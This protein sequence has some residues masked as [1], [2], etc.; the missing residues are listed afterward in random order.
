MIKMEIVQSGEGAGCVCLWG[1][2]YYLNTLYDML[3]RVIYENPY[4]TDEE[5][6]LAAFAYDVRKA[7]SSCRKV[8]ELDL[9]LE[10]QKLCIYGV[11]IEIPLLIAQLSALEK[12]LSSTKSSNKLD[13]IMLMELEY[14]LEES[15]KSVFTEA[16]MKEIS[17]M[18]VKI[19]ELPYEL[20]DSRIDEV[21]EKYESNFGL[22]NA[23]PILRYIVAT[24]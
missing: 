12:A 18:P 9:N 14:Y 10:G 16:D 22:S 6:F 5:G 7:F 11:D 21:F 1:D 20:V 24:A 2:S 4:I 3:N 13:R 15:M 8:D 17:K 19:R 23:L